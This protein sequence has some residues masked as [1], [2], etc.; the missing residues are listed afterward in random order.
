MPKKLSQK[1]RSF[2]RYKR[3]G[4]VK[5]LNLEDKFIYSN[6]NQA[7]KEYL[8]LFDIDEREVYYAENLNTKSEIELKKLLKELANFLESKFQ[9]DIKGI[10]EFHPTSD[11]TMKSAHIHYWGAR[12]DLVSPFIVEFIKFNHLSN[13]LRYDEKN[14]AKITPQIDLDI[15]DSLKRNLENLRFELNYVDEFIRSL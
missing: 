1:S 6:T 15:V 4:L 13:K 12:S 7:L 10:I 9:H 14:T 8:K 2:C 3:L 11:S 5:G